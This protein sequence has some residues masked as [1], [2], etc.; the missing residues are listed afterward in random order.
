[1]NNNPVS[2][3]FN[4]TETASNVISQAMK[5]G[6]IMADESKVKQ[7]TEIC[8]D[9]ENLEKNNIRC[10]L[11]GCYMLTKIRFDAAKCPSNKW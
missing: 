9:C 3:L 11:C 2:L 4:L 10:K 8:Y 5:S 1:M 6:I 7:R